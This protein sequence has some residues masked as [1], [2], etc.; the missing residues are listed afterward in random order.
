ML[1]NFSTQQITWNKA[2]NRV[3]SPIKANSGDTNGRTLEVQ[4]LNGGTV[5]DLTGKSVNLAWRTKDGA[6][7]G[8]DVFEAIDATKGMFKIKYTTGMLSN[9]GELSAS[10]VII[11]T[12]ERIESSSF[13]II[14]ERS[15]VNDASVQS[16]N[17]FTSLTTALAEVQDIDN[18]FNNV[19]AQ[20]ALKANQT[21][22]EVEKARINNLTANAGDVTNNA[23]LLDIR[24]G[25]DGITYI[26][27]G[28]AVRQTIG[29]YM[30]VENES[31]VV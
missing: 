30:T 3:Y 16:E 28:E 1:D 23:E 7:N 25:Y 29:A 24:V 11:G 20:L 27:A 26:T 8:L 31:W 18:K 13:V 12:N 9:V 22:L 14:V 4:I 6:F 17:S 21:A 10:I 2:N 5:E 19:N 15:N